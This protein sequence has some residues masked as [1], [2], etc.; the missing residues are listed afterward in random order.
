MIS[1]VLKT[2]AIRFLF[3]LTA[4]SPLSSVAQQPAA[5]AS[6]EPSPAQKWLTETSTQFGGIYSKTV[7]DP[8]EEEME[9]AR[10]AYQSAIEAGLQ[11]VS[12]AGQ[13]A[14]AA[15]LREERDRFFAAGRMAPTAAT[16][17]A[18]AQ[19]AR[20]KF[21]A[22]L[23]ALE[24][25]RLE[26]ARLLHAKFDAALAQNITL[27]KQRRFAADA[28]LLQAKREEIT[29]E[30]LQPP[31]WIAAEEATEEN[32]A[33]LSHMTLKE[34]I[35]WLLDNGARIGYRA[36]KKKLIL[37]DARQLPTGHVEFL[38]VSFKSS[39]KRGRAGT[40]KAELQ[41]RDLERLA[42]LRGCRVLGFSGFP[43]GDEAFLF[44]EAWKEL[45]EFTL[46][47]ASVTDK[48]AARLSRF[49]MLRSL[50]VG[51]CEKLTGEFLHQLAPALPKL[52]RLYLSHVDLGDQAVE[53][54]AGLKHLETLGL[55]GTRI[56]DQGLGRLASLKNLRSLDVG[57][58]KVTV[59]GLGAL[60][61]LKLASLGFL[62]TDNPHF[63]AQAAEVAKVLPKLE[64]LSLTG[65]EFRVE[66]A[67]ALSAFQELRLV[68]LKE[69]L[70]K[71]EA[72]GALQKVKRLEVFHCQHP[73]FGDAEMEGLA[74]LK[75]LKEISLSNTAL[76]NA[77]LLKLTR[78]KELREVHVCSTAVTE[79]GVDGL[80][81]ALRGVRVEH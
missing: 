19:D 11:S 33:P 27:L 76:T 73:G 68:S 13:E 37:R 10:K 3:F 64:G 51:S 79:S 67:E 9:K 55:R 5:S 52:E 54:L 6:A 59:N 60:A 72:I 17:S 81:K 8:Y 40:K 70:P 77:G 43:L 14:E 74:Q 58:T 62:S 66:H 78:N 23:W 21:R 35:P 30:W 31:K 57:G 48:L 47:G 71:A 41:D 28:A 36:G 45:E 46:T 61:G 44:L 50:M 38:H 53:D 25:A 7:L 18:R 56:T 16:S 12:G 63:A 42:P 1:C 49:P 4:V 75:H 39:N 32:F 22:A 80:E 20:A 34:S 2:S 69:A 65:S 24:K 29:R 26:R 15:L